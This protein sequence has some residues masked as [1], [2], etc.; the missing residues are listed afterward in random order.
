M[1]RKNSLSKAVCVCV[2]MSES[3]L[4]RT[5]KHFSLKLFSALFFFTSLLI[6]LLFYFV[7]IWIAIQLEKQY[8]FEEKNSQFGEQRVGGGGGQEVEKKNT[9]NLTEFQMEHT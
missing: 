9:R 2:C 5:E 8:E 6:L 3:L 4:F 1:R 7:F